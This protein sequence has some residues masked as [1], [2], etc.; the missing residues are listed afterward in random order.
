MVEPSNAD[1]AAKSR[2]NPKAKREYCDLVIVGSGPAGLT[3][4]LYA[5]REGIETLVVEKGVSGGLVG[6]VCLVVA[7]VGAVGAP[8]VE[9]DPL[10]GELE[11]G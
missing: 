4:A 11:V 5:A 6:R 10:A 2:I 1:L 7:A 8:A 9:V 3:T